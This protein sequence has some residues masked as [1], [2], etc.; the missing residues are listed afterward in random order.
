MTESGIVLDLVPM[1]NC[2]QNL[3][4]IVDTSKIKLRAKKG[5]KA[6]MEKLGKAGDFEDWQIIS[7]FSMEMKGFNLRQHGGFFALANA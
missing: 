3:M 1:G 7:E 5:R 6:I 2:P 4:Y